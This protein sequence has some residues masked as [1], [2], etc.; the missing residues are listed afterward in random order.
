MKEAVATDPQGVECLGWTRAGL[1]EMTRPRLGLSL[2]ARL[3][4]SPVETAALAALRVLARADGGRLRLVAAPEVIAW[5]EV[6]GA[7]ALKEA[8]HAVALEAKPG[9]GLERFDVAR[10]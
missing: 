4:T 10:D 9:Y 5:L 7:P 1:Y 6:D 2:S 3:R 8:G